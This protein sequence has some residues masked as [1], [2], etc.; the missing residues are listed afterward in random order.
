MSLKDDLNAAIVKHYADLLKDRPQP[1]PPHPNPIDAWARHLW[2][3]PPT[4]PVV[5]LKPSS[6]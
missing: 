2:G 4:P 1:L 5:P 3:L 6:T